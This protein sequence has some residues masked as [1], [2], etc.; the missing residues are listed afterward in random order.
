MSRHCGEA[1]SGQASDP[2]VLA[3]SPTY[4]VDVDR[5]ADWDFEYHNLRDE[6]LE[7]TISNKTFANLENACQYADVPGPPFMMDAS[8]FAFES[9]WAA[10]IGKFSSNGLVLGVA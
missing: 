3:T 7:N 4:Y 5:N 6:P 1:P 2:V 8:D 10:V 9:V